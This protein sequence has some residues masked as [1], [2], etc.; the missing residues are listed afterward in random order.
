[1]ADEQNTD[2]LPKL[3]VQQELFV[4]HYFRL[5]C[6]GV[7]AAAAAGYKGNY[8]TLCATA[9]RLL[10]TDKVS[11]HVQARMAEFA[12]DANEVLRHLAEI[13]RADFGDITD[14]TGNLD[15]KKAR[16]RGATRLIKSVKRRSITTENSDISEE[17]IV[18]HDRL[19]ALELLG[20][21]HKLFTE[22]HELTGADGGAI[23]VKAVDYRTSLAALS[24]DDE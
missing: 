18:M 23:E 1:M 21:H 8:N 9:S 3:S 22:R 20:K 6:N 16:Q 4:N 13:G 17:E 7:K 15:L 24:P 14:K 2:A 10:R 5:G 12:M 19:K 11:S